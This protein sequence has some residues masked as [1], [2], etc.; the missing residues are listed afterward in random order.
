MEI[1]TSQL[2]T[3][4]DAANNNNNWKNTIF[5]IDFIFDYILCDYKFFLSNIIPYCG[6]ISNAKN[7]NY[8]R[9]AM[10]MLRVQVTWIYNEKKSEMKSNICEWQ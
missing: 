1:H 4:K 2:N 3:D 7:W 10:H 5:S 9:Y 8:N 6:K